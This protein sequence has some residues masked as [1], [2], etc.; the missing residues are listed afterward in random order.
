MKLINKLLLAVL[1]VGIS[2]SYSQD[3]ETDFHNVSISIPTI[4]LLDIESVGGN[5]ITLT[6]D[7]PNEA[8]NALADQTN[9]S[10]WLNI[11]SIIASGFENN[12]SVSI[13]A[14]ITGIDLKVVSAAYSGSGFGSWGTAGSEITLSTASQDLVTGIKSGYTLNGPNNGYNLTYTA[15]P[16]TSNF[17]DIES[18]DTDIEVTYTLAP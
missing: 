8:G 17:G 14:A 13:D 6:M 2:T 15:T 5:D 16:N 10:L 3:D 12:I 9:S 1:I 18:G 11:T 7:T 4:A